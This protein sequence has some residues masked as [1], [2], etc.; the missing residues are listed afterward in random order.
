MKSFI[1]FLLLTISSFCIAQ[2]YTDDDNKYWFYEFLNDSTI[3][4]YYGESGGSTSKSCAE[5]YRISQLDKHYFMFVGKTQDFYMDSTLFFDGF[6]DNSGFYS[7]KADYY[8]PNGKL[9]ETGMYDKG[10]RDGIWKYYYKNG[11]FRRSVEFRQNTAKL[12]DFYTQGGKQKVVNGNGRYIDY[13][14]LNVLT[15]YKTLVRGEIKNGSFDG[16]WTLTNS[17]YGT[18]DGM[19]YYD[20]GQFTYGVSI[21]MYGDTV[22]TKDPLLTFFE[23]IPQENLNLY[24]FFFG[25]T[26]SIGNPRYKTSSTLSELFYVELINNIESKISVK[27]IENQWFMVTFNV[28]PEKM[29]NNIQ[30]KSS[31][32]NE[33]LSR[34]LTGIFNSMQDWTREGTLNG[35]AINYPFYVVVAFEN[36]KLILPDYHFY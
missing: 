32:K 29:L 10:Y 13:L 33:E 12:I 23:Y 11:D 34:T 16:R 20:K 19:E 8:S 26:G 35:K 15:T 14:R 7:G 31:M 6:I 3:K 18:M 2:K 30:V 17:M 36:G 21:D 5:F 24:K 1:T 22:H 4:A 25:C 27:D 9:L 28:S